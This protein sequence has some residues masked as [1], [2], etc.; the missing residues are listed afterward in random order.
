MRVLLLPIDSGLVKSVFQLRMGDGG[1][2]LPTDWK[3][4]RHCN[5]CYDPTTLHFRLFTWEKN[6]R[7]FTNI[8]QYN[9]IICPLKA[10][11]R[12]ASDKNLL[13]VCLL[14]LCTSLYAVIISK[15]GD[16]LSIILHCMRASTFLIFVQEAME[17]SREGTHFILRIFLMWM[18][19]LWGDM[20]PTPSCSGQEGGCVDM[21]EVSAS[22]N[23][24][25]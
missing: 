22:T 17:L 18:R 3:V 4:W 13:V 7:L 8:G 6:H 15:D 19:R 5:M 2:V 10:A 11:R 1:R 25:L 12:V 23:I 14:S 21:A 16:I 20:E 9:N 24:D